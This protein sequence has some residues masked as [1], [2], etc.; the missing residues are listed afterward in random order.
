[1]F[2]D[3]HWRCVIEHTDG[4][5]SVGE[6]STQEEAERRASERAEDYE[7]DDDD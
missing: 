5:R 6:A 7:D 1:M 2:G 3:K 4:H